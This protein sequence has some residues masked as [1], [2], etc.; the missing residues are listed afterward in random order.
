MIG[1][2]SVRTRTKVMDKNGFVYQANPNLKR[3]LKIRSCAGGYV[4]Y[5]RHF[6]PNRPEVNMSDPNSHKAKCTL[7]RIVARH[8]WSDQVR[9]NSFY[10]SE[11]DEMIKLDYISIVL[12]PKYGSYSM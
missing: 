8:K 12:H 9:E 4:H 7:R 3:T 1:M 5:Y 11:K 2:L 6:L 10:V